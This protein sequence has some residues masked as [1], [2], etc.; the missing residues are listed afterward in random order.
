MIRA[1]KMWRA[2]TNLSD[3]LFLKM[4]IYDRLLIRPKRKIRRWL[5]GHKQ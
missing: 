4:Y 5:S 1:W 3:G 2:R